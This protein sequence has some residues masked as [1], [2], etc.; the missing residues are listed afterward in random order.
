MLA[1]GFLFEP[2]APGGD[3]Y[4]QWK[5]STNGRLYDGTVVEARLGDL[6][7]PSA[8]LEDSGRA[9]DLLENGSVIRVRFLAGSIGQLTTAVFRVVAGPYDAGVDAFEVGVAG[10]ALV[11]SR[12][13]RADDFR[14]HHPMLYV[15][16][17]L[18]GLAPADTV[19]IEWWPD[20]EGYAVRVGELTP[21]TLGFT[22]GRG[23]NLLY[24]SPVRSETLQQVVDHGWMF[25]LATVVGWFSGGALGPMAWI[26][27]ILGAAEAAARGTQLLPTPL[28]IHAAVIAGFFLGCAVRRYVESKPGRVD[29]QAV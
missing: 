9:R 23:W 12:R 25:M 8:R 13:L 3:Y 19:T 15:E 14:L 27:A 26:L 11:L 2:I 29:A 7:I 10:E 16:R 1:S 21:M 22:V 20:D 5:P 24:P 17:A 4:G 18:E 28:S 6:P